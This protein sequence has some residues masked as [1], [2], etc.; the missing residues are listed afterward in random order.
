MGIWSRKQACCHKLSQWTGD[1]L[2]AGIQYVSM[3]IKNFGNS[4]LNMRIVLRG[5]GGDFWSLNPITIAPLADWE[6]I[7]FSV[8]PSDMTGAVI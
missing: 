4:T 2:S 1:Y 6:L 5:T 3:Y 7:E 8:Q